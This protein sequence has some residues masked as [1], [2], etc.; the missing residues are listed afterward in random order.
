MSRIR[1]IGAV[2]LQYRPSGEAG[3]QQAEQD[4][5]LRYIAR[6]GELGVHILLFQEEY[7]FVTQDL[8][9]APERASFAPGRIAPSGPAVPAPAIAETAI[10]LD[11]PYVHRVQGAARA[12]GVNVAL[13]ILER[14]GSRIHNSLVPVTSEGRL[15]TPYRKMYPVPAGELA[16]GITPGE[17]NS[18]QEIAGIPVSFAICFDL[19]FDDV[20]AAARESGARLVLWSS[21]WM[22][23]AWLRAQALRYGMVIVSAT[24]D[25]CTFADLDGTTICESPTQWPQTI[26]H[27]NLVFEDINFDRDVFHCWADGRLEDIRARYGRKVHMRNHPQDS[28]VVIE[29]LDEDLSIEEIKREFGLRTWFEYIQES[30]LDRTQALGATDA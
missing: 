10:G 16:A 27:N 7:G 25:G 30:R 28:I 12:A 5:V 11:A 24:P 2:S 3:G 26:G 23:G 14:A 18:A 15:L 13:P 8:D 17:Q 1:R 22:G 29:S 21:M 9:A 4:A 19:H 6:A 20:F